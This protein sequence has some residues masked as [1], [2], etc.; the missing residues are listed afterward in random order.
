MENYWSYKKNRGST[1]EK[2]YI[3]IENKYKGNNISKRLWT[4]HKTGFM[5]KFY[6]DVH[7]TYTT[8]DSL[9]DTIKLLE[10]RLKK[11]NMIQ[12]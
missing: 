4:L 10:E 11:T 6:K 7:K 1:I 5:N 12:I 2:R 9:D 3:S 8:S